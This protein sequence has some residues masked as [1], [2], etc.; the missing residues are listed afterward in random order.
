M[1]AQ[2]GYIQGFVAIVDPRKL[3]LA[4]LSHT[5]V[6]VRSHDEAANTAFRAFVQGSSAVVECYTQTGDADYLL[7]ILCRDLDDL[8]NFLERMVKTTGGVASV[9]SSI[10]LQQIKRAPRLPR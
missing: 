3:G 1:R 2:E 5:Q 9:R 7:K 8:S 6:S 10:A 4:V